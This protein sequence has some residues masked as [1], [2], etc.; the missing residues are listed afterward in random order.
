MSSMFSI[1]LTPPPQTP[2]PRFPSPTYRMQAVRYVVERA[3]SGCRYYL[4][5]VRVWVWVW[6]CMCVVCVWVQ[7][8][9]VFKYEIRKY[10]RVLSTVVYIDRCRFQD[11][12]ISKVG[13]Q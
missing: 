7:C 6:V 10:E 12:R 3:E 13:I 5:W 9:C 8:V 11:K 4:V 2:R 1:R